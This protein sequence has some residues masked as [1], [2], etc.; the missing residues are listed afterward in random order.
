VIV[1]VAD[2]EI[3][4]RETGTEAAGVP[5]RVS[6]MWQVIG[7]RESVDIVGCVGFGDSWDEMEERR[8]IGEEDGIRCGANNV[9]IGRG[10]K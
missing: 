4:V 10:F 8:A 1:L 5:V 2:G 9:A 7:G 6:R 3:K